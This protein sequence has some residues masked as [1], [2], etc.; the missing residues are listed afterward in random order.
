MMLCYFDTDSVR[1][2]CVTKQLYSLVKELNVKYRSLSKYQICV[3]SAK[4]LISKG[5]VEV[6]AEPGQKINCHCLKRSNIVVVKKLKIT[7]HQ[8]KRHTFSKEVG[9]NQEEEEEEEDGDEGDRLCKHWLF[10]L[11]LSVCFRVQMS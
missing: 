3:P 10:C 4:A 5:F 2:I 7:K 9:A 8:H 6:K 11:R 1:Y